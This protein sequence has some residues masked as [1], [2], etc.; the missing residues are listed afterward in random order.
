MTPLLYTVYTF[1]NRHTSTLADN[2]IRILLEAGAK[3]EAVDS[4][5]MTTLI[6][7]TGMAYHYNPYWPNTTKILLEAG[8]Q[9]PNNVWE[10]LPQ[11]LKDKYGAQ[12][13]WK[14]VR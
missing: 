4:R 5:Q 9:I 7:A 8:A 10:V 2:I 11:E 13:N 6:H 14:D 1:G 12:R 3:V